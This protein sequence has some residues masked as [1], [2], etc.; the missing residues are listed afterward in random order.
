[1]RH[2]DVDREP[3]EVRREGG[4]A[5]GVPVGIAP[6]NREVLALYPAMLAQSVPEG[7][8]GWGV[9]TG[10]EQH[11]DPRHLGWRL[12]VRRTRRQEAEGQRQGDEKS[13]RIVSHDDLL[14]SAGWLWKDTRQSSGG[15]RGAL[16]SGCSLT[17]D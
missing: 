13:N 14:P 4:E 17:S 10:K 2:E 5:L 7:L 6:R 15:P 12:C 8:D 16:L 1:M 9:W 3:D 11:P